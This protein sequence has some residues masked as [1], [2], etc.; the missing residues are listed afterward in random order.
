MVG[1]DVL[2]LLE[3]DGEEHAVGLADHVEEVVVGAREVHHCHVA[4]H[5]V[6]VQLG[7]RA[8]VVD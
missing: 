7:D 6:G 1:L 8:V 4:Q 5:L 3:A 2:E